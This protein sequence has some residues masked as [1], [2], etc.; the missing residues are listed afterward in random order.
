MIGLVAWPLF[1][2]AYLVMYV[3]VGRMSYA[4]QIAKYDRE[5][6]NSAPDSGDLLWFAGVALVCGLAWPAVLLASL[7]VG[8]QVKAKAE[9][10]RERASRLAALTREADLAESALQ[11]LNKT[12]AIAK[13]EVVSTTTTPEPLPMGFETYRGRYEPYPTWV[14]SARQAI[15]YRDAWEAAHRYER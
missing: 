10:N 11:Q 1:L 9:L 5:Y 4:K 15:D 7:V 2:V 13:G 6:P 14:R 8:K 3:A 12:V